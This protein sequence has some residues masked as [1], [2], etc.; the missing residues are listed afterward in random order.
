MKKYIK[1]LRQLPQKEKYVLL[2][3]SIFFVSIV[4][5]SLFALNIKHHLTAFETKERFKRDLE[6]FQDFSGSLTAG[7]NL[8]QN[9]KQ[10]K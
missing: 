10:D 7:Y 2:N 4:L 3:T 5:F 8:L 9:T 1:K 6:P